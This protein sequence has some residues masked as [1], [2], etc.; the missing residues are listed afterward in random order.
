MP[1]TLLGTALLTALATLNPLP[2]ALSA[3]S[4]YPNPFDREGATRLFENS[5]VIVWD[6]V[7]KKGQSYPLHEHRYDMTGIFTA[8][9]R[10]KV[11]LENGRESG[12]N[13]RPFD[14]PTGFFTLKGVIHKEET[15]GDDERRGIMVELKDP[16]PSP[17]PPRPGVTPA[18]P[19]D[20]AKQVFDSERSVI[21][22]YTLTPGAAAPPLY[23]DKDSVEVFLNGGTVR[24]KIGGDAAAVVTVKANDARFASRGRI[25]A[26]EATGGPVRIVVIELK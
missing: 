4:F 9:G 22:D 18:F 25:E 14:I 3:Q 19:R 6:N 21:W 7:W 23:H 16:N 15:L 5:R 17:L 26:E 1:R 2:A 11:T 10:V 13:T 12:V 20:G 8:W 24:K